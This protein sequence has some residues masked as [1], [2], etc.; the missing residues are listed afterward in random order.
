[1]RDVRV[2]SHVEALARREV[3]GAHVIEEDEGPHEPPH[4]RGQRAAHGEAA[5]VPRARFD[6]EIDGSAFSAQ[7]LRLPVEISAH[8]NP[9]F[10]SR[11]SL[12]SGGLTADTPR[13][14]RRLVW[15]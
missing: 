8:Q 5:E 2:R 10:F 7:T 11:E 1:E 4:R 13:S 9:L 15:N 14:M 6:H 12:E 3:D